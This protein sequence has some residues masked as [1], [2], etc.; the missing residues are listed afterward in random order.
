MRR[1]YRTIN[2]ISDTPWSVEE[3]SDISREEEQRGRT[4]SLVR[5][6]DDFD[7]SG[8]GERNGGRTC[9]HPSFVV[10]ALIEEISSEDEG[11]QTGGVEGRHLR[12]RERS[13]PV[14]IMIANN[15][16]SPGDW[17]ES[18]RETSQ[19][20]RDTRASYR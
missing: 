18:E 11:Q 7:A 4:D 12:E 15:S 2:V 10:A 19:I 8:E 1:T 13:D 20:A 17:I 3:E 6:A 14:S 5:R 9:E 16:A